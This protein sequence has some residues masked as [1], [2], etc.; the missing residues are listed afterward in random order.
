MILL[1]YI[2]WYNL[3]HISVHTIWIKFQHTLPVALLMFSTCSTGTTERKK[4]VDEDTPEVFIIII[5]WSSNAVVEVVRGS[6][7]K[8]NHNHKVKANACICVCLLC[9]T[10]QGPNCAFSQFIWFNKL[11]ILPLGLAQPMKSPEVCSVTVVQTVKRY[12]I[13]R[14]ERSKWNK[15]YKTKNRRRFRYFAK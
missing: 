5:K 11:I 3:I 8:L 6:T 13:I 15:Y 12:G 10:V 4:R 1:Y 2:H 9:T 14:V 7:L